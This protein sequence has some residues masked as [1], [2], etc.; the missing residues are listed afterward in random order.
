MAR[1]RSVGHV[2]LFRGPPPA[3]GDYA[4]VHAACTVLFG[5]NRNAHGSFRLQ[6]IVT[7][8]CRGIP[9]IAVS[10]GGRRVEGHTVT[11][12]RVGIVF[13]CDEHEISNRAGRDC[14]FD[15]VPVQMQR[16]RR[17]AVDFQSHRVM[18]AHSDRFRR[19][20]LVSQRNANLQLLRV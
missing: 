20:V 8:A 11:P 15:V 9:G 17:V 5:R 13:R 18:L 7:P 4:H 12:G 19:H 16:P 14:L 10:A 6:D 2:D 3:V 1:T